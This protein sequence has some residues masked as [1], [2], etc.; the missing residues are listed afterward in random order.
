[1]KWKRKRRRS[2]GGIQKEPVTLISGALR[3]R[4]VKKTESEGSHARTVSKETRVRAEGLVKIMAR[5]RPES[6]LNEPSVRKHSRTSDARFSR[7]LTPPL[8]QSS[9]CKKCLH[10]GL[11]A[12]AAR[13]VPSAAAA[14]CAMFL[15]R[16]KRIN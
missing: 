3:L 2:I 16:A 1:M 15:W 10:G 5:E 14:T 7:E 13:L 11:G 9:M 12:P 6:G 4:Y 8:D